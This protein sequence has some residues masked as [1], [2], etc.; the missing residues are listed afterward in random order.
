MKAGDRQLTAK[1]VA[2]VLGLEVS[3]V[4]GYAARGFMP[5]PDGRLGRTDWWWESNIHAWNA[6]RPGQGW[7]KGRKGGG[8]QP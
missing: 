8:A 4:R 7:R 6:S 1:D 3:T 2:E 5:E